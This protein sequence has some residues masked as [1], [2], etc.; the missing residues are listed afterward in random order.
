MPLNSINTGQEFHK[1][2]ALREPGAIGL[3]STLVTIQSEYQAVAEHLLGRILVVDHIDH[4][5]A[6]ARKYNYSIRIVTLEGELLTPGGAMT[7]GAYKNSSNL[8]GRKRELDEL[9]QLVD[10]YREQIM[11]EERLEQEYVPVGII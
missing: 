11:K 6:I 7:G 8:L 5:L 4:A 2:D 1:K 9:N 10:S 3:A